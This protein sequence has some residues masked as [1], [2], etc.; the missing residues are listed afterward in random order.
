VAIVSEIDAAR[1]TLQDLIERSDRIVAFTGAGISTE[2]GVPDF[3]SKN[4]P[5]FRLKPIDFD[6][7]VAD[8]L[9]REEA[10]RRKFALDDIYGHAQ[11]GRGHWALANLVAAS[12]IK[13]IITQNI[14]NLHQASGV[15]EEFLIELH[16]NGAYATCL[17]CGKRH[18]LYPIRQEFMATGAA[19]ICTD[20]GGI[21]KTATISFGQPVP[22]AAMRRAHEVATGCDLFLA[23]GS[24]LVVYPAAAFPTIAR[25]H[26]ARLVIVN[27]EKTPLDDEAEVILRG[28]IGDIFE[29]FAT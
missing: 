11:P 20:C 16:G 28:D 22:E 17:A 1:A 13:A 12:K 8:I 26:G 9:Q 14:D 23:I 4:S 27:D 6:I 3:R 18:E 21:V 7:F 24:S 25:Q 10:W 19:P 5:W 2:C 15:A 29:P